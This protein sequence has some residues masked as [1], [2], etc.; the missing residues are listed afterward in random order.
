[1]G[2]MDFVGGSNLTQGIGAFFSSIYYAA[3]FGIPAIIIIGGIIWFVYR[4]K[5]WNLDVEFKI[6]RSDGRLINAEW[7]K[8]SYNTKRGVVFVKRKG[9]AKCPM[10]PFD[11]K[12]YLQ[13]SKTLTV[14][15]VGV[16]DFRPVLNESWMEMIDEEP[17]REDNGEIIKGEDGKPIYEKAA[18][19]KIKIDNSED[20]AWADQFERSAKATYSVMN[21]LKEYL[22]YIGVA[23]ILVFNFVGFAILWS[24]VS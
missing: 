5:I 22:P 9:I 12:K 8:G 2:F 19:M 20:Q 11:I 7:G 10:K 23:I 15:Q 17:L 1:M 16:K 6:P 14:V 24:K 21:L 3:I 13:G 18:L 4:K